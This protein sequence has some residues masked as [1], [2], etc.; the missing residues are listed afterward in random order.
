MEQGAVVVNE[1]METSVPYIYAV[2]AV[3]AGS[4]WSH[5]ANVEGIIAG[6][7]A[8]GLTSKKEA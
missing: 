6:E 2:G 4:M 3:T 5:K 1:R 8:M 7:N